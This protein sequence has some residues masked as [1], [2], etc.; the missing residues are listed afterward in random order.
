M[1][2]ILFLM[3]PIE[4]IQP[5][6]DTTY[7]LML[8]AESRG[9]SIFY[10]N[11]YGISRLE[12]KLHFH[13]T[14]LTSSNGQELFHE[15]D[16]L[17]LSEDE[18]DMVFVRTDPPFDDLYLYH[19]WMLDLLPKRIKVI[20]SASGIRTMNEKI[21]LSQFSDLVP[22]TLITCK[23]SDIVNFINQHH[24]IVIKPTNGYGGQEVYL[25]DKGSKNF[26]VIVET[27]TQ[28]E[29][30]PVIVQKY[31]KDA[32]IGD[33]R[34]LLLDG[35]PIGAVLRVHSTIDHRN[36]FFAGGTPH[37]SDLTDHD[38]MIISVIKPYLNAL[39]LRFVGIDIIGDY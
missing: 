4:T 38:L 27:I 34:I 29:K 30:K 26:N 35:D 22:P 15:S 17:V 2:S 6:K 21:W 25:I 37:K 28:H 24:S 16:L 11:K 7:A 5:D 1:T 9:F 31:I 14:Q 13:V 19:T 39:G 23:H 3:D 33:K 18:V 36:N 12:D 8:E 20:N 32:E 10:C